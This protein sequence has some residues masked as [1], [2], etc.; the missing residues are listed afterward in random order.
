MKLYLFPIQIHGPPHHQGVRGP[1]VKNGCSQLT[2]SPKNG[3]SQLTP[4]PK[5]VL[6][7]YTTLSNT[8]LGVLKAVQH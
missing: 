7:Y 4:S 6:H 5:W 8:T 1:Q 2:P 3:C